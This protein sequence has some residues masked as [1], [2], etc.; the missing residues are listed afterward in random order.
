MEQDM[1]MTGRVAAM[2]GRVDA[3]EEAIEAMKRSIDR[4]EDK[5]EKSVDDIKATIRSEVHELKGEQIADL[6]TRV[7]DGYRI[8][9]EYEVRLRNVENKQHSYDTAGGVVGWLIK[10]AIAILS[11]LAGAFGW[12]H[13][14]H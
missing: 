5:W 13:L 6:K 10:T 4:M 9:D 3:V 7:A 12:E 11:L 1:G 8:L 2:I 14:R